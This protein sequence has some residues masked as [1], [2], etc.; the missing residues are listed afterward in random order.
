MSLT[1][2][3]STATPEEI[4]LVAAIRDG[5]ERAFTT[6]VERHYGCMLALPN[7]FVL[8]PETAAQVVHDAWTAALGEVGRFDGRT[9]LRPWLLRFVVR[10]AG[11]RPPGPPRAGAPGAGPP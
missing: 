10:L 6:T 3:R 8:A 1:A 9:A 4:H 7:A 11:A 5:D 2:Q